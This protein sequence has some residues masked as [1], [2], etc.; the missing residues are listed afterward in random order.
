MLL[1]RHWMLVHTF[2]AYA[3]YGL[4]CSWAT[5][6]AQRLVYNSNS[7]SRY[8]CPTP[9]L[10]LIGILNFMHCTLELIVELRYPVATV[11]LNCGAML[12]P[13][14][15]SIC[16]TALICNQMVIFRTTSKSAICIIF[17]HKV[18]NCGKAWQ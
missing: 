12:P 16:T 5:S 3:L 7:I 8:P 2:G 13:R 10:A 9:E 6:L 11:I 4:P 18:N 1:L 15:A 17:N 14:Q